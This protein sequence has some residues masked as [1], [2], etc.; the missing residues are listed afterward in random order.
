MVILTAYTDDKENTI[1][2]LFVDEICAMRLWL[3]IRI[4]DMTSMMRLK[5]LHHSRTRRNGRQIY[6][7]SGESMHKISERRPEEVWWRRMIAIATM[8]KMWKQS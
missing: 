3:I 2:E 5:T 8:L 6:F 1:V 7:M 4:V